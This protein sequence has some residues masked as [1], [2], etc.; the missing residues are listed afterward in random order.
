MNQI[1]S[2]GYA[3]CL[4]LVTIG[5]IN[6]LGNSIKYKGAIQMISSTIFL[7]ILLKSFINFDIK[8]FDKIKYISANTEKQE[9]QNTEQMIL[10]QVENYIMEQ[11]QTQNFG[12]ISKLQVTLENDKQSYRLKEIFVTYEG[13]KTDELIVYISNLTGVNREHIWVE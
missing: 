13:N 7:L 12:E 6:L 10:F 4:T 1:I 2:V 9:L 3:I 5:I 8:T 11:I